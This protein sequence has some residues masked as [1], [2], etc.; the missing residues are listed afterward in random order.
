MGR[1][2][3]L[4]A[5]VQCFRRNPE[6]ASKVIS[7]ACNFLSYPLCEVLNKTF[8]SFNFA[9]RFIFDIFI[10]KKYSELL[11]CLWSHKM[12]KKSWESFIQENFHKRVWKYFILQAQKSL[13]S[14][15]NFLNIV[16]CGSKINALVFKHNFQRRPFISIITASVLSRVRWSK[17]L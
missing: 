10:Q 3:R 4:P 11:N 12:L 8:K 7:L 16:H 5:V 9:Q 1:F 15:W 6:D 17:V 13:S 14:K 2:L